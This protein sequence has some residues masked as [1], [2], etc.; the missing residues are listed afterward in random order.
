M[1]GFGMKDCGFGLRIGNHLLPPCHINALKVIYHEMNE[2][3]NETLISVQKTSVLQFE[4]GVEKCTVLM[5][6]N[7]KICICYL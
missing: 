4:C 3:A 7:S 1:L 6:K 2:H 5:S